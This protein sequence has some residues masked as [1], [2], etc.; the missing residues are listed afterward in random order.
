MKSYIWAF[1]CVF[2]TAS[3]SNTPV[4]SNT[5]F[6]QNSPTGIIVFGLTL[7]SLAP[8]PIVH[9]RK[10]DP[11]TGKASTK[12]VFY[13]GFSD[14]S[15]GVQHTIDGV[16][17]YFFL[18]M[19]AGHWY[20]ESFFN[21]SYDG[22]KISQNNIIFSEGTF[23]FDVKPGTVAYI[24]EYRFSM[25]QFGRT[26]LT[27]QSDMQSTA[28]SRLLNFKNVRVGLEKQKPLG[29]RF[30]CVKKIVLLGPNECDSEKINVH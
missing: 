1:V 3:C 24:G 16:Q 6:D 30:S 13:S 15:T 26:S 2:L 12:E 23:A 9:F 25:D 8:S 29:V 11:N 20:L 27:K 4:K 21:S 19:P 28:E 5:S 7:S 18:N 22:M 10:Y 17:T 14:Q